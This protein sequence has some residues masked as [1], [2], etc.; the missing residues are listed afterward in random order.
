MSP[1]LLK[2]KLYIP[3]PRTNLVQRPRLIERLDEGLRPDYKLILVSAPAGFGKT[4]LLSTWLRRAD[5]AGA[6]LSLDEHDNDLTRFLNYLT[7][8]LAQVAPDLIAAGGP[9][10]PTGGPP[11]SFEAVLV[12][13]INQLADLATPHVLI[14]DDY[15]LISKPAVD[16]ALVFLI[17]RT[18][19]PVH[20]AIAT[21]ADPS[22]P[23]PRWR[24]RTQLVETRAD[25]LRFTRAETAEFLQA[26]LDL[27]LSEQDLDALDARAEGWIAALQLAAVSMEGREDVSVF[28]EAFSGSHRYLLD[29]L[30][31]EVLEQQ[32]PG[33]RTF[34]LRTA[35]LERLSPALCD[36]V[37]EH[38]DRPAQETLTALERSNLFVIPLDG[39][40]RWYRYHHLFQDFLRARLAVEEPDLPPVLHRRAAE[41][42]ASRD[43]ADDAVHHALAA[44]DLDLAGTLIAAAYPSMLQSGEVATLKRWVEALPAPRRRSDPA[45]MLA[46]A[47]TRALSMEIDE[48]EGCLAELKRMAEAHPDLTPEQ[49]RELRGEIATIRTVCAYP[50]GDM[51]ATIEYAEEA[52]TE[53]AED[54]GVLRS[55]LSLYLGNA[56]SFLGQTDAASAAYGQAMASG[57]RSGNLLVAFSAMLNEGNLRRLRGRWPEAAALYQEGLAWAEAHQAQPLDG[58]AHVGLG[59]VHWDR[60]E[61]TQARHHLEIGVD[62]SRRIGAAYVE[63]MAARAL[64]CLAQHQGNEEK[65]LRWLEASL[66]AA[67]GLTHATTAGFAAVLEAEC[68]LARG[69]RD[70]LAQWLARRQSTRDLPANLRIEEAEVAA[71][72]RLVLGDANGALDDLAG[73]YRE[74]ESAGW[75]QHVVETLILQ[76]QAH[77]AL[78]ERRQALLKLKEALELSRAGGFLRP[79]VQAGV[80]LHASLLEMAADS[81]I[82]TEERV[83]LE[84][85]L[86]ALDLPVEP[87]VGA[88]ELIEPLTEREMDVLR[89]LPTELSTAEIAEQLFISYHTVRTHLKH[90]YGKL[91][92][93]SR[94]EAVTR[95]RDLNLL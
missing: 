18:P 64:A 50:R 42:Y 52:L 27:T 56:Y 48:T 36:A 57:R 59:L 43:L 38:P 69:D 67:R 87:P 23:L 30:V 86:T 16:E 37:L 25:D 58:L 28:V 71:H 90:I 66:S 15:H 85:V 26:T 17:D 39:E 21:R 89:L 45:L 78:S 72:A 93:H 82:T 54:E 31:E 92:A 84:T 74:A 12:P 60:W 35:I 8:A 19:P 22:L 34:L 33:L 49:R 11:P 46:H 81:A 5:A 73:I 91:D 40:R 75:T 55:V 94:H 32:P 83:F 3:P 65:A 1:D 62:R 6:W 95:S 20:V 13:L 88:P 24:A 77:E 10:M 4:T 44:E 7:A 63:A 47:W 51:E 68:Q 76:G 53:L 2:T 41:W 61:T 14:L 79:L 80:S 9:A 70:P 29:Y